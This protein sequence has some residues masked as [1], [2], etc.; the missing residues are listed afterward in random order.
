MVPYGQPLIKFIQSVNVLC[1]CT[2][3]NNGG[4]DLDSFPAAENGR[5]KAMLGI[6]GPACAN[7]IWDKAGE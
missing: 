2:K 4:S 7:A 6:T 5:N 3:S 1:I